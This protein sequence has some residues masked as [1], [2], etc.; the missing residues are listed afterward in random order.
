M[1]HITK[2]ERVVYELVEAGKVD[3]ARADVY[4]RELASLRRAKL[5]DR[6][7]TDGSYYIIPPYIV[8]S[9]PTSR[10]GTY[11]KVDPTAVPQ[12]ATGTAGGEE[13]L[14]RRAK[15]LKIVRGL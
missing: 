9:H 3:E 4:R 12:Q 8:Q 10:S 2:M 7:P 13:T 1:H 15:A 14:I 6:N 11:S 5:V